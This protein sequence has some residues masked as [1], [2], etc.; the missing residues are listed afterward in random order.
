[1]A[2]TS[3]EDNIMKTIDDT[4]QDS[5]ILKIIRSHPELNVVQ[6]DMIAEDV[7]II[8]LTEPVL[9]DLEL[10][11]DDLIELALNRRLDLLG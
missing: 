8:T 11:D 2:L 5:F 1:M 3:Q 4:Y 9:K 7:R 6:A 10:M